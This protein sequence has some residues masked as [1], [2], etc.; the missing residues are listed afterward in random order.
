MSFVASLVES[1][2]WPT[3]A[4]MAA[5]VFMSSLRGAFRRLK[6]VEGPGFKAAFGSQLAQVEESA[7]EVMTRSRAGPTSELVSDLPSQLPPSAV[8]VAEMS[9]AGLAM[10]SWSALEREAVRTARLVRD[11]DI[12]LDP[13]QVTPEAVVQE[14]QG[15]VFPRAKRWPRHSKG[16][17]GYATALRTEAKLR[18]SRRR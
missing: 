4:L 1:L 2:A 10:M 14:V 7:A 18:R 13:R 17:V 8:E 3:A 6:K 15:A 11:P 12:A 16:F 9:P 5:L